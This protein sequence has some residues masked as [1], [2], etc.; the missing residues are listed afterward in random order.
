MPTK[1]SSF[2]RFVLA[3]I[4]KVRVPRPA[5]F[6]GLPEILSKGARA[7]YMILL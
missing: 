5:A 4:S 7:L 2:Y 3:T 6:G 1:P